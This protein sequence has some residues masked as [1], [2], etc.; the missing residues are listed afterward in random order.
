MKRNV[1]V[2]DKVFRITV[3]VIIALLYYFQ[4]ITGTVGLVLIILA[5]VFLL[6]G[7]FNFCGLYT[8]FGINTCSK[9]K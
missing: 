4:V 2:F 9:K 8:L 6:T 3:A 1:G 5:A 7:L